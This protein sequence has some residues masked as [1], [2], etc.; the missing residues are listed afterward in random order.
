M[1]PRGDVASAMVNETDVV[2]VGAG[3]AGLAAA[4]RLSA[5]GIDVLVLEARDRIG[6]RIL[7]ERSDALP[8][9]IELGAEFL[10]GDTPELEQITRD[11]RL[12]SVDIAGRRWRSRKGTLRLMDGFWERLDVVMRRLDAE[13]TPDRSFADAVARMRAVPAADR[14]LATQYVEGFH[15]ADTTRISERSLAEGGSPRGDVRER[16]IG[17]IIEGYDRVIDALA[18]DILPRVRR[19]ARVTRIR[20]SEG[21]VDVEWATAGG[22]Q[23]ST[24]RARAVV[25]AVP[26]GVLKA[27]AGGVG[28]IAFDPPLPAKEKAIGLLEMGGV[29]RVALQMDEPFWMGERF[30]RSAGD[31]RLDTLS[32]LH[33][34]EPLPFPVWWTPYPLRAPLLVA[35]RGGPGAWDLSRQPRESVIGAAIASLGRAVGMA[36]RSIERRVIGAFT[37]DWINDPFARGAYSYAGVGGDTAAK[38]L[39]RPVQGTLFFA[40][41]HADREGRN[42]TVHGAIASGWAAAEGILAR[43]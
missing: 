10:H 30:A 38:D 40:G 18:A 43:R 16:R 8:V 25:V 36:R 37:H 21:S 41:E 14:R 31:E 33:C 20:W 13:R 15:A 42:G 5:S 29:M 32:F 2:V 24:T 9:P 7:T 17:R 12:R 22:E 26:L 28:A 34:D 3:A 11:F 23:G 6:G 19:G 4:Q 39:A 27:T 35:W 1:A